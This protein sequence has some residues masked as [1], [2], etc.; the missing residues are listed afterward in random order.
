MGTVV[1]DQIQ[2]TS[3]RRLAT[4]EEK[5]VDYDKAIVVER[6]RQSLENIRRLEQDPTNPQSQLNFTYLS[7]FL[8]TLLDRYDSFSQEISII[9]ARITGRDMGNNEDEERC[10]VGDDVYDDSIDNLLVVNLR[11]EQV[12]HYEERIH[13]FQDTLKFLQT[14]IKKM[15]AKVAKFKSE[16]AVLPKSLRPEIKELMDKKMLDRCHSLYQIDDTNIVLNSYVIVL[17]VIRG[18]HEG[19]NCVASLSS[20]TRIGE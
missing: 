9:K 16:L 13:Y 17:Q 19:S 5:L 2:S 1:N 7:L 14:S 10:I 18:D 4:L 15:D 11:E 3:K 20:D 6:S 8:T 12:M